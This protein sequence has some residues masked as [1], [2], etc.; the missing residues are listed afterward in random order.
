MFTSMWEELGVDLLEGVLVYYTTWALLEGQKTE[1]ERGKT[2]INVNIW[3]VN[4]YPSIFWRFLLF[5]F[6]CLLPA[7]FL[8]K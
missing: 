8:L 1:R 2:F 3:I 6:V 7:L 4:F 5:L